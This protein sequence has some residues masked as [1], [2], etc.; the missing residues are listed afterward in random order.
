MIDTL[1]YFPY[2]SF[3]KILSYC[4]KYPS[5]LIEVD[6]KNECDIFVTMTDNFNFNFH[7]LIGSFG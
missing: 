6:I 5:L 3:A 1:V 4:L 2:I 7:F